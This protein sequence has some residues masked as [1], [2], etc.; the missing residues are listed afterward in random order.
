MSS[1]ST[2]DKVRGG[3]LVFKGDSGPQKKIKKK[4]KKASQQL[5]ENKAVEGQV[6]G[7]GDGAEEEFDTGIGFAPTGAKKTP[8]YEDMFPFEAEKYA[9]V[10]P[11]KVK[12][13]E[14]ALDERQKRKADRYCK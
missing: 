11:V 2:F 1:E 6:P 4:K 5:E 14:S 12:S 8:K 3:K 9:Y 10:A 13:R 7:Q